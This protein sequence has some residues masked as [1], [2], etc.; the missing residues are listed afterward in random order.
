MRIGQLVVELAIQGES[1]L[2]VLAGL[3]SGMDVGHEHRLAHL[4]LSM[5]DV[6]SSQAHLKWAHSPGPRW[7]AELDSGPK[8]GTNLDGLNLVDD[9]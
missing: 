1:I 6:S 4:D 5:L 7:Q 8:L 2:F 9:S 3:K